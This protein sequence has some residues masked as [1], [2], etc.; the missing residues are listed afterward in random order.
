MLSRRITM[1]LVHYTGRYILSA[2]FSLSIY[3]LMLILQLYR[4]SHEGCDYE[5]PSKNGMTLHVLKHAQPD[6]FACEVCGKTFKRQAYVSHNVLNY[7]FYLCHGGY[8]FVVLF[9]FFFG[10]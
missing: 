10:Y 9:W 4:C 8:V 5:C 3:C 2:N 1:Y 7:N 6:A